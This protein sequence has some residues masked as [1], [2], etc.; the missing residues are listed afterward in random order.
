ME[1]LS[2]GLVIALRLVLHMH[3]V[4]LTVVREV[5]SLLIVIYAWF[6][7]RQELKLAGAVT[8]F[9]LVLSKA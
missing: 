4:F 6:G 9:T 3:K 2:S 7:L 1:M 8:H 5:S